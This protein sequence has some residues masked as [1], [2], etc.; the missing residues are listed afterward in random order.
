MNVREL[1]AEMVRQ[2]K[3][4]EELCSALGISKSAWFRK[5]NGTS[6]F[7]Q[8]EISVLR[9]ELNLDAQQ[10]ITIFFAENVS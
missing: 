6:Q 4:T 1:K 2:G 9:S 10:T 8:G 5:M 7:D 3:T